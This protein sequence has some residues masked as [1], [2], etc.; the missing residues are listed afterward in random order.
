MQPFSAN[1]SLQIVFQWWP[2]NSQK[3]A[4][5][6]KKNFLVQFQSKIQLLSRV[7]CSRLKPRPRISIPDFSSWNVDIIKIIFIQRT[8]TRPLTHSS[9]TCQ[10]Y[11]DLEEE[12]K[13]LKS[14]DCYLLL[15]CVFLGIFS[16]HFVNRFIYMQ[17]YN[18]SLCKE[19]KDNHLNVVLW[20]NRTDTVSDAESSMCTCA[21]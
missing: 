13:L 18:F 15:M 1:Y 16:R 10:L 17:I 7:S 8:H 2:E 21:V 5:T 6:P 12:K 3:L 20:D 19:V 11:N 4:V 14:T 9:P